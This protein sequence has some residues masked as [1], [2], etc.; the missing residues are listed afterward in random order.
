MYKKASRC[1][2]R[3]ATPKG[4]LTVDQLWKTSMK[5]LAQVIKELHATI[6]ETG[7]NSELS[8]LD[9][10]AVAVDPTLALAYEVVKDVY[11]T[12]KTELDSEKEATAAKKDNQRILEIIAKK[13][14]ESLAGKSVEELKAMLK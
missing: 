7:G 10:S 2:L 14:E 11:V 1:G 3:I 9:E 12:R 6:Q 13:E 8:F 5:D 4:V